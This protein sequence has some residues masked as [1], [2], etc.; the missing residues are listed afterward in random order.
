VIVGLFAGWLAIGGCTPADRGGNECTADKPCGWGETC[1]NGF[2]VSGRCATS[3]Q[4]PIE[5]FCED[6]ACV[7]GCRADT[8]CGPGTRCDVPLQ[9][10][11]E[12][13]CQDT[14]VDCA[15]G[16]YCDTTTGTCFD[17]GEQF[18]RPCERS[19]E[20]GEG[21]VCFANFCGVDCN[22]R[23]CP[24][25]FDCIEITD[26]FDNITAFQCITYCPLYE[27]YL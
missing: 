13:A 16:E 3:A 22:D 5:H 21:N 6:D 8:D 18:C 1:D 12:N 17:A 26:Q 27:D 20:C 9:T 2:C 23:E 25:G 7:P 24:A 19:S 15:F 4:C 11:I 14:Q 10:C